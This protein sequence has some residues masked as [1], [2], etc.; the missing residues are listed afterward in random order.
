[1]NTGSILLYL[2][3]ALG[4]LSLFSLVPGNW[5]DRKN[6]FF[7]ERLVPHTKNLIRASVISLSAT[8]GLLVYYLAISD[9]TIHYVW[10]YTSSD[11]PLVY[12]ISA[13]WTGQEGS[14]L[15]LAWVIFIA[16]LWISERHGNASLFMR[17]IQ[18]IVLHIGT[19]FLVIVTFLSPFT[20]S[21]DSG[22]TEVPGDGAGL[23]PLLINKWMIFHPP[24]IFIPYGILVVVFAS[25]IAHMISG[26]KEW[27][28]FSRP[29][30]RI[31]W[32][33]LGAGIV[34]GTMWSYEVWEGYWIWDPAFTS[35][36][37]TWLF[38]TAYMHTAK[39]YQKGIMKKLTPAI[40]VNCFILAMFSTYVIRSG[41]IQS[42]HAFGADAS[43]TLLLVFVIILAVISEA[44]VLYYFFSGKRDNEPRTAKP[45]ILSTRN[46]FYAAIIL[47]A[48]LSFILFWGLASSIL[49]S[50]FGV[51]VST[52]LYG[53]WSFPFSIAL[54]SVM[55]ICMLKSSHRKRG[56][57]AGIILVFV[58]VL[59]RPTTDISLNIAISILAFA[60]VTS[61]YRIFKSSLSKGI[62]NKLRLA[63]THAVHL[64]IVILLAGV[65]MSS[66]A[67][68]ETVLFM[69]FQEKK[70]VGG[71]DIELVDLA[72]PVEHQ[73]ASAVLTKIGVYNIYKDGE[74]LGSGGASFKEVKGEFIIDPFIYRGLLADVNVRYQGIGTQSPIFI[75]VANVKVIPGMT[76][77]WAG[78][79]LVFTGI[80]P[81]L[82][83]P[84]KKN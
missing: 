3:L 1:M 52:G 49:L 40:A 53:K 66:Y 16:A 12:K 60:G 61:I 41:T 38:L 48:A 70:T 46:T 68:S 5:K 24:G 33:V 62:N 81:L 19:V 23:N 26:N 13:L 10:K 43:T 27:E 31:A 36:L 75:S 84:G 72:F 30:T 63:G 71:Y 79:I 47:L 22:F 34:T 54:L 56:M 64:G 82:L 39:M 21:L 29:Y 6:I 77:L 50:S 78:S 51:L 83:F 57:V 7:F 76:F 4:L 17:R 9:Y 74:L 20:T 37:M 55:G 80:I 44:L 58:I 42:A 15:F 67:T 8:A 18:T 32:I 73:H 45:G 35:I 65:L 2:S 14:I 25:V 59:I 69:N 28:D 11:L